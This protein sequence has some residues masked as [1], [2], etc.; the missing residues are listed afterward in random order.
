MT[1][2]QKDESIWLWMVWQRVSRRPLV[3]ET[4]SLATIGPKQIVVLGTATPGTN[5]IILFCRK[6]Q[7][8]WWL[9]LG[10]FWIPGLSQALPTIAGD[11]YLTN[12]IILSQDCLRSPKSGIACALPVLL[13][14]KMWINSVPL[15]R[16]LSGLGV[17][18]PLGQKM[19]Y[20]VGPSQP[21]SRRVHRC[22]T[23]RL[24]C[25]PGKFFLFF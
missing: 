23:L 14:S 15:K 21:K 16:Y 2:Y 3:I 25:Q 11:V 18:H 19:F 7:L 20:S 4:A 1:F 12:A 17:Y 13:W 8:Y 9:Y 6:R 5:S 24:R 22:R 10:R